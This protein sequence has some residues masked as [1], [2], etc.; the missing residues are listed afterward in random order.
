MNQIDM[1]QIN[2]TTSRPKPIRLAD[3]P[4]R[5]WSY[6]HI[7]R[8]GQCD[9]AGIVYTP[10]FFNVFNHTVE[11]WFCEHLGISYYDLIGPRR[12]GLGYAN[13]HAE[14]FAPVR[15]GDQI[16]IFIRITRIGG[17]SY[18]L[19]LNAMSGEVESLR[20]YFTTVTTDLNTHT[21][22]SIPVE[23]RDALNR[24]GI[25]DKS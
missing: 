9:P 16:D 19:E 10:E 23:V 1:N 14:F 2:T 4:S 11:A 6:R 15:M 13:A 18:T 24:Y 20:G 8:H 25:S 7:F 17:K 21:T 12:I 3:L 22:I 5:D